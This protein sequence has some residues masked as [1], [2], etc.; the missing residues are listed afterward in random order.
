MNKLPGTWVT[1]IA[2]LC[3]DGLCAKPSGHKVPP[4]AIRMEP[5]QARGEHHAQGC[6]REWLCCASLQRGFA[7]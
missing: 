5:R 7:V 2:G 1:F 6:G 3:V 4:P